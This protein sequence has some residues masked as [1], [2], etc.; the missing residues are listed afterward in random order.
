M[1]ISGISTWMVEVPQK[2]PIAPYRSHIRTSSTTTKIIVRLDTHEGL[3]G[4]GEAN[5]NFLTGICRDTLQKQE[6]EW[7]IGRDP[8]NIVLFHQ[9]CPLETRLKAGIELA[10]WDIA[11]KASGLPVAELLGGILRE[12]VDLAACMGIQS[13]DRAG[14]IASFYVE[15][16]Y[17]TLKTKAGADPDEDFE[18][19]RGVYDAVGDRLQLRLDP[20]RAYT[21]DQAAELAKRLEQ[22]DLQYFEQPITA[23]PLSDARWLRGQ[24]TTPIALNESVVFPDSVIRILKEDAAS[25]ILPDTHIAGGILPC[26]QIGHIC[27]AAGVPCI[28]H[29][30]HDLGPKTAAMIHIAASGPGYSLANDCTYFGLVDDIITERIPINRG[31]MRVPDRPGLGI[32][33][34]LDKLR[35]YSID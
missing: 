22:F 1:K 23:E 2:E 3:S 6:S 10:M 13:Y 11:G 12:E 8:T 16:G 32:E 35:H 19:A 31:K 25:H 18:M 26:V 34:D 17:S 9:T 20:N 21:R 14:E 28:M 27:A 4:W 30:G 24:T 15:E 5:I 29:C 33:C 7:L